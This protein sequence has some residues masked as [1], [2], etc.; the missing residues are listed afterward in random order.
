MKWRGMTVHSLWPVNIIMNK[1]AVTYINNI[2]VLHSIVTIFIQINATF[3]ILWYL[4]DIFVFSW[5][6]MTTIKATRKNTGWSSALNLCFAAHQFSL[7][8][9]IYWFLMHQRLLSRPAKVRQV[10]HWTHEVQD[11]VIPLYYSSQVVWRHY[12]MMCSN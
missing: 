5:L 6:N 3:Y 1:S 11:W 7:H 8:H 12:F 10:V 2:H 4:V 9:V